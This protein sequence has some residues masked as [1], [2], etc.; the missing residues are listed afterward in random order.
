MKNQETIRKLKFL[1]YASG[2]M[3]SYLTYGV[4]QEKIF[5]DKYVQSLEQDP[6]T[7]EKFT[8]SVAFVALQTIVFTI[9]A[10]SKTKNINFN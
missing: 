4:L 10:K 6:D 3:M 7:G 8:F 2:I 1:F 9:F 5:K